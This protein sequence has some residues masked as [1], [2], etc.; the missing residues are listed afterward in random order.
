MLNVFISHNY[1]DKPLARKIA[2]ELVSYGIKP[3]IDESEIKLG[4]SLIEKIRDGLDQV[5]Y[6]VALISENSIQSEWVRKELDIAMT[7]EI[8]GKKITILPILAGKC[9]LPLFLKGK[10]YAD[11]STRRQYNENIGVLLR[12]FNVNDIKDNNI[13]E[14]TDYKL[15]PVQV[16]EKLENTEGEDELIEFLESFGYS[17]RN[18]FYRDTFVQCLNKLFNNKHLSQDI[19][20]SLL[21]I[22]KYC[23]DNYMKKLNLTK[24]LMSAD[25]EVLKATIKVLNKTKCLK[26][27]QKKICNILKE[28]EDVEVINTALDFFINVQLDR[29]VAQEVYDFCI[30]KVKGNYDTKV[31]NCLCKISNSIMTDEIFKMW[32]ATWESAD[33]NRKEELISSLC[34]YGFQSEYTFLNSPKLRDEIKQ[35]LFGS[36]GNDDVN[37]AN[38]MIALLTSAGNIFENKDEVWGK[39]YELDDYSALLTLEILR[40]KYIIDYILDSKEDLIGLQRFLDS[41]NPMIRSV[42]LEIIAEIHSKNAI[43]IIKESGNYIPQY[44][45]ASSVLFTLVKETNVIEYKEVYEPVRE[46]IINGYCSKINNLYIAFC[47]Y[48]IADSNPEI[49]I[50]AINFKIEDEKESERNYREKINVITERLMALEITDK[51]QNKKIQDFVRSCKSI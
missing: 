31:M 32:M 22:C 21:N 48:L 15:T 8:E 45:N 12:K 43:D 28:N 17:E 2:N 39:M 40:D 14:F 25:S 29:D 49:I 16:I 24:L 1:K 11:M 18:L 6:L 50:S 7:S 37:N 5:D 26:I 9:S 30:N 27:Q 46:K 51:K 47:D 44:Y 33:D 35:I 4:D 36:F 20:V 13:S 41:I 10:L 3:W 23:P 19:L 34:T 38:I 42:A